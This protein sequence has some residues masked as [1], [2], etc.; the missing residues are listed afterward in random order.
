MSFHRE[1][2]SSF[3]RKAILKDMKLRI[4][5]YSRDEG[6]QNPKLLCGLFNIAMKYL[7]NK[8]LRSLLLSFLFSGKPGLLEIRSRCCRQL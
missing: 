2:G 5:R 6:L 8:T 1:S 4:V 3:Q 7:F